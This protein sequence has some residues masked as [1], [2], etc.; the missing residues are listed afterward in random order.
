M[1]IN[2]ILVAD[3]E[4]LIRGFLK[5]TLLR[6]NYEVVLAE[7]GKIAIDLLKKD[8]SFDLVITD[9]K[10]PQKTGLDVLKFAKN[11]DPNITVIIM[12]A[13]G[14]IENAVEAMKC[15]AFNYIIKPFSPQSIET[16]IKKAEDHL[17][18]IKENEYLREVSSHRLSNI[19][20]ESSSMKKI[21]KDLEKIAKSDA[22]IFISGESGTGKEVIAHAIYSLSERKKN[23]FIKVNCAA[24]TETLLESEF[25]GH[26]K[27]SFTGAD[28]KRIGRFELADKGTLLLDEVTEIPVSLQP[29]LLRAVQEQEFER[30]GGIKPIK[31]NIRFIATSNRDM[32]KAIESNI[33][34]EDLYF[35]LNV[36]PIYIPPLRER[37]EDIIPLSN[38]FLSHFCK[39]YHKKEKILSSSAI[40]KLLNYPW[41]GNIRELSNIIE[42][43]VVL[44]LSQI[45]ENT[46]LNIDSIKNIK[47]PSIE[48]KIKKPENIQTLEAM[49]KL[50]ILKTLQEQNNNKTKAAKMLGISLRTLRNKL[51]KYNKK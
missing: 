45:I 43:T 18:L 26:E 44:D 50:L 27:G 5:T 31:V 20:F 41:P 19:I 47:K 2:K 36:M 13:F 1:P 14:S 37:K 22:S 4:P 24:I 25:F 15:G 35:R 30:V 3:D 33:V 49:E 32:K 34:R 17:L 42:R 28:Q 39:K 51:I 48:E 16:I 10:M 8:N 6:Q 46:H 12:T 29:K 9:M 7:N 11:Y 38:H 40:E 23:P 21:L